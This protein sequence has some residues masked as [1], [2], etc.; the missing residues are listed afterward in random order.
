MPIRN[1]LFNFFAFKKKGLLMMIKTC[2][3]STKKKKFPKKISLANTF[4]NPLS[5]FLAFNPKKVK[6]SKESCF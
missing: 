1:K 4:L 3:S 5:I 2:V 6:T